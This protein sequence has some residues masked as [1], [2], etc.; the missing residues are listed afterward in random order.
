VRLSPL[1]KIEDFV[2]SPRR[3]DS[4]CSSWRCFFV[5]KA[6]VKTDFNCILQVSAIGFEYERK[7]K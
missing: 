3:A 7:E 6:A 2:S 4:L 1:D 5:G